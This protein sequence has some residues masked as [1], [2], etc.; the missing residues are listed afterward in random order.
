MLVSSIGY[1]NTVK[2]PYNDYVVTNQNVKGNSLS[3]GFGHYDNKPASEVYQRSFLISVMDS[4]KMLF[5]N[6]KSD[7]SSKY[8]SLVA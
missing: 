2:S 8:L 1:L 5:S 7:E 6:K 4:F 3:E